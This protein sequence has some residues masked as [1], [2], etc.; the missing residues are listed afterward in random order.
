MK[1]YLSLLSKYRLIFFW[2]LVLVLF[3][4]TLYRLGA[5]NTPIADQNY[6]KTQQTNKTTEI[7]I[8]ESLR[9]ELEQ[10]VDTT[11]NTR[12]GRLGHPDPFNP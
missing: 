10:L 4:F 6:L 2:L 5:L 12:P 11:V 9:L 8:D 7:K 1:N 3:G